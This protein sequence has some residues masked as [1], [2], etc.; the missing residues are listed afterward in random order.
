MCTV[1]ALWHQRTL[2]KFWRTFYLLN[3]LHHKDRREM[4][5]VSPPERKIC[6]TLYNFTIDFEF[7]AK[8]V[9]F[10]LYRCVCKNTTQGLHGFKAHVQKGVTK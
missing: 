8:R 5:Y 10:A 7:P 6:S 3:S 1:L 9:I 4:C 2:S